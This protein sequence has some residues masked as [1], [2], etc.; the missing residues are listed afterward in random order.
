LYEE[1]VDFVN[2]PDKMT[3]FPYTLRS[4]VCFWSLHKLPQLADK[5]EAA[6]DV[7]RIT[8]VINAKTNSYADRRKNFATALKIFT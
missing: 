2:D 6:Q 8:K 3:E 5:G 1:E 4:A 7:D